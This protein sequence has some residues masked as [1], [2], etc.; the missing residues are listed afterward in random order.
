MSEVIT[1]VDVLEKEVVDL[2]E[3]LKRKTEDSS[4]WWKRYNE[5]KKDK[6]MFLKILEKLVMGEK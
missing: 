2:K 1:R 5:E 4:N 6:E 3:Q